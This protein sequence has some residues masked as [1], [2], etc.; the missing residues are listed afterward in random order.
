MPQIVRS[1]LVE[2]VMALDEH[3]AGL[4]R[5]GEKIRSMPLKTETDQE[6]MRKMLTKFAEYGAGVSDEVSKLSFNLTEARKRAEV[7][8]T[9]VAGRAEELN[10]L[11]DTQQEVWNRLRSVTS[12]LQFI[13][14][15]IST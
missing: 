6:Q 15:P 11:S 2:S 7:I 12:K 14:Q 10:G 1:P 4:E 13:N 3:F 5:I 9:E 8:A